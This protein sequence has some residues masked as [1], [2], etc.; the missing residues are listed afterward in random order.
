[1]QWGSFKY[2]SNHHTFHMSWTLLL[3]SQSQV[4]LPAEPNN[5]LGQLLEVLSAVPHTFIGTTIKIFIHVLEIVVNFPSALQLCEG[6]H[7]SE[8][9]GVAQKQLIIIQSLN[10]S[11][12]MPTD[13]LLVWMV[14]VLLEE[15]VLAFFT[16]WPP[17]MGRESPPCTFLN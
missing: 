2:P 5:R 6:L 10:I 16:W 14:T 7:H 15:C 4:K 11:L 9:G 3:S 1:M 12:S 13:A 8:V 17:K